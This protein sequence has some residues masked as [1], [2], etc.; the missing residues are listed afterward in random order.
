M[1]LR[2]ITILA[3]CFQF[4]LLTNCGSRNGENGETSNRLADSSSPYL[5]E[6]ADNP[7]AW[8]EWGPEALG[9]AKKEN[10]PLI[11]SI[12]YSSCHW[13]H[14]MEE[15]SFMDT[16]VARIMNKNF[17]SIKVDGKN[18]PILIRFISMLHK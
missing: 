9:K 7:V 15:E 6:H 10:K 4:A 3:L 5:K 12:G 16:A 14:V 13:C 18:V 8:Y 1:T 11:I 2:P 17:I